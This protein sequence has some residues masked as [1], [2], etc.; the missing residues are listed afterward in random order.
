[1]V[2]STTFA[3]ARLETSTLSLKPMRLTD[4]AAVFNLIQEGSAHGHFTPVYALPNYMAGL[5]MQL[6]VLLLRKRITLPDG[7]RHRAHVRVLLD[8]RRF[9]GFV[10]LLDGADARQIYMCSVLA[11]QRGKGHGSWMIGQVLAAL[12]AGRSVVADCLPASLA[13]KALLKRQGFTRARGQAHGSTRRYVR[14]AAAAAPGL[15][16][17]PTPASAAAQ[18]PAPA[19][20]QAPAPASASAR[21]LAATPAHATRRG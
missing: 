8:G 14:S 1:M 3:L 17:V 20:A 9:A 6:F 10:I 21:A 15:A 5:G 16:P 13:M 4:I 19:P 2:A 12:P 18:A 7:S 11:Q